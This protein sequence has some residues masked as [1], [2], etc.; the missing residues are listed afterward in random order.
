MREHGLR[1]SEGHLILQL[2]PELGAE[3]VAL[4]STPFDDSKGLNGVFKRLHFLV[5]HDSAQLGTFDQDDFDLTRHQHVAQSRLQLKDAPASPHYVVGCHNYDEAFALVYTAG[6]I[7]YVGCGKEAGR[8][9]KSKNLCDTSV[10]K[11]CSEHC[12]HLMRTGPQ[13]SDG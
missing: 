6:H 1:A 7:L 12:F 3:L 10:A 9:E 5:V 2:L 11:H 4:G 13:H 8:K